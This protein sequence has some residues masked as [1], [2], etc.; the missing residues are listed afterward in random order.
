[1]QANGL[2]VENLRKIYV[3]TEQAA[4]GIHA[5]DFDLPEGTFFTLLG[6]SGWTRRSGRPY[7]CR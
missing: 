1:M 4:G 7:R 5:A 3:S 2:Q 6:P